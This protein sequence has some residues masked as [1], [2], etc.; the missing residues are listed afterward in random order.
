MVVVVL[1][2]LDVVEVVV[3]GIVDVDVDVDV[4]G[5]GTVVVG[6][7]DVEVCG[8]SDVPGGLLSTTVVTDVDCDLAAVSTDGLV[9]AASAIVARPTPLITHVRLA[10]FSFSLV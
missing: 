4:D 8:G 2:V 10:M 7:L 1:V 9:A 5:R 6:G 3:G